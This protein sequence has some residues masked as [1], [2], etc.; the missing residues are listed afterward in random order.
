MKE[1]KNNPFL[2]NSK[3]LLK[4]VKSL[5]IYKKHLLQ[6]NKLIKMNHQTYNKLIL[7]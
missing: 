2:K 6:Y 7:N 4:L 5:I 3:F 1:N